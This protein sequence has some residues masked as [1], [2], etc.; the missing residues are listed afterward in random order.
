MEQI[1]CREYRSE[2]A[3]GLVKLWNSIFPKISV[4]DWKNIEN[5]TAV[6]AVQNKEIIGAIPFNIRDFKISTG[7]TIEVAFEHAVGVRE[8]KRD[9]GIGTQMINCA[10]EFMKKYC[11]ALFVYRGAERSAGYRFYQKTGHC[12][13]HI[14]RKQILE[15][16]KSFGGIAQVKIEDADAIYAKEK[17][18]NKIFESTYKNFGGF[19]PR[20]PGYWKKILNSIIYVEVRYEIKLFTIYKKDILYAYAVVGT[21]KFDNNCETIILEMAS[22]HGDKQYPVLLIKAIVN[23]AYSLG[24]PVWIFSGSSYPYFELFRDMGFVERHRENDTHFTMG[25]LLKPAEIFKK[26]FKPPK[27]VGITINVWTPT[28]EFTIENPGGKC[29]DIT[30]EMK[31][32]TLTRLLLCRIKLDEALKDERITVINMDDKILKALKNSFP[33]TPWVYHTIDYI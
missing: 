11:D 26:L 10:K 18:L 24:S 12:D 1:E 30:L 2:D 19:P 4:E 25:Q 22:L 15:K 6:V 21:R 29:K 17:I 14:P 5:E 20:Y 7:I 31:D 28:Q 9:M 32:E 27:G 16:P 13:L 8:D 33:F 3:E 23:M